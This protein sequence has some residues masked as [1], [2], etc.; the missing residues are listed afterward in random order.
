MPRPKTRVGS[1]FRDSK[2]KDFSYLMTKNKKMERMKG[3]NES[4][5]MPARRR[6]GGV[7]R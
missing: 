3:E 2:I 6:V 1:K 7:E 4:Q 5:K